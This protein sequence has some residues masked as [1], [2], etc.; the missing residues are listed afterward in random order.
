LLV[1][2]NQ[3]G[4]AQWAR[5]VTEGSNR[6]YFNS[7]SVAS[8]GSVY[9]AGSI[10]GTGTYNFGDNVTAAGADSSSPNVVLVQYNSSGTA[11]WARTVIAGNSQSR[12][13]SVSAASDGS[14]Y[15]AGHIVGTSTYNFGNSVTATG[16]YA[17][18]NIL[19]VKYNSSG[20]AQ[21]ARTVISAGEDSYFNSVSV[22]ADGSVYAAGGI[23]RCTDFDF[24]NNI[25][26]TGVDCGGTNIILVKYNS[27]GAA[28]W[29]QSLIAGSDVSGFNSVSVASDGSVY[30]AGYIYGSNVYNF[31]NSVTVTGP[32]TGSNILLVKYSSSGSAQWAQTVTE[33]S[34]GSQFYGVSAA[35][36]GSVYAAG[37]I[38]GTSDYNFGNSVTAAGTYI[39]S[40][41]LLVKY[42]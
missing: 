38:T 21:W 12:F 28:Q 20:T 31:G 11:Q 8:D 32:Y 27:S 35:S 34:S 40:N 10:S 7:V 1:K 36:D 15:A 42:Y 5:T 37:Y 17:F 29:V 26:V 41:I 24:G 19:L 22:A 39:Y 4:V 6:S 16:P 25:T 3:Y 9:A 33:E 30:A 13:D 23:Q 18:V 14:V 2:Y